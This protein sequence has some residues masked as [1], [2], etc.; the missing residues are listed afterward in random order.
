MQSF[1]PLPFAPRSNLHNW[2]EATDNSKPEMLIH[3]FFSS[4]WEYCSALFSTWVC[5]LLIASQQSIT[6]PQDYSVDPI[7]SYYPSIYGSALAPCCRIQ[8]RIL[9]R[10][11]SALPVRDV[12]VCLDPFTC[13]TLLQSTR[14]SECLDLYSV[15]FTNYCQICPLSAVYCWGFVA[16]LYLLRN[17][18]CKAKQIVIVSVKS[19]IQIPS[20]HPAS[21]FLLLILLKLHQTTQ[22]P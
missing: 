9:G 10:A 3:A 16:L 1:G 4:G 21:H 12:E 6:L 19:T 18:L 20:I 7:D 5:Y 17:P 8:F 15:H 13:P 14:A 22:W 2:Y 11:C